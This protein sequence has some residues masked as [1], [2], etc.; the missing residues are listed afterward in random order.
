MCR[1]CGEIKPLTD[2]HVSPKRTDGRGSSFK[3]CFT[4]RSKQSYA[5]R[6]REEYGREV[7]EAIDG[8]DGHRR[9]PDRETVKPL[10]DF[11]RN[12]LW[13]ARPPTR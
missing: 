6:V 3:G 13:R 5:K 11:P 1:D 8:P 4:E 12:R 9:S 10:S 7:R 2:L